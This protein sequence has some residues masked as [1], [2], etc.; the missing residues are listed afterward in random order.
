[1]DMSLSKLQELVTDREAWHAAIHG[2][3]KS[4]TR[5]SDRTELILKG[6]D[7]RFQRTIFKSG[8]KNKFIF[9]KKSLMKDFPVLRTWKNIYMLYTLNEKS[10]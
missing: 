3:T 1:M 10:Y 6:Q 2:V 5:L 9:K 8:M 4:Q 7:S